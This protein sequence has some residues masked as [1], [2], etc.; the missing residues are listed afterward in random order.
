MSCKQTKDGI[1]VLKW[2]DKRDVRM[3]ST[4]TSGLRTVVTQTRKRTPIIK[5]VIIN[6]YNSGKTSIDISDQMA[7]YGSALRRCTKW[8]RKL[9]I[10][11]LWG[12][13]LV[14]AHFLYNKYSINKKL[15]I[16]E[17]REQVITGLLD[18]HS[19]SRAT[20]PGPSTS[21]PRRATVNVKHYLKKN[22]VGEK[23]VR[24]R[25]TECYKKYGRKGIEVQGKVVRASQVN[26][27]CSICD[28]IICK[29]CFNNTH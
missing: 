16:T 19:Q 3:L 8:Y 17:F 28:V 14:N 24:G 2:H 13:S 20:E 29:I 1:V 10:E 26:T 22:V 9:F 4:K 18:R 11:V 6:D 21:T 23:T 15:T 7:T 5:P 12:T 27:K 25:C